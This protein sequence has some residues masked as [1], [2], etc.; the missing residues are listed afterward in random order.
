MLAILR[1]LRHLL[2]GRAGQTDHEWPCRRHDHLTGNCDTCQA[3]I[4]LTLD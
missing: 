1:K 3:L 2:T 4:E